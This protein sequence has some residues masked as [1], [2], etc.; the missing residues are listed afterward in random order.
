MLVSTDSA[1]KLRIREN[2]IRLRLKRGE[3]DRIACGLC[4][5]ERTILPDSVFTYRLDVVE[6]D[7]LSTSFSDGELVV[8]FPREPAVRWATTD[9]VSFFAEQETAVGNLQVLIEK[10]FA[11]LAPGDNR[12]GEDDEDSFPHPAA[13]SD[14]GC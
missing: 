8:R 12:F 9:Q 2:T 6:D 13:G 14:A 10:D 11:C 3:V 7:E 1:V 4:V 5:V